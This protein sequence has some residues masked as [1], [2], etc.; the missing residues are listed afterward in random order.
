MS[1]DAPDIADIPE[2]VRAAILRQAQAERGRKGGRTRSPAQ[3]AH[4]A[5][6]SKKC[7]SDE[8]IADC[9]A[10]RERGDKWD[11]IG[12]V[13]GVHARTVTRLVK[14]AIAQA[15]KSEGAK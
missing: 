3:R 14:Q 4:T 6:L 12:A 1:D 9:A 5:G 15:A 10:R 7:L 11:A 2:A 8:E 13:Y